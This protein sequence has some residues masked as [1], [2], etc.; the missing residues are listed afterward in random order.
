MKKDSVL[1][2]LNNLIKKKIIEGGCKASRKENDPT[3]KQTTL[4]VRP[5]TYKK[6][7]QTIIP[8][9]DYYNCRIKV[10]DLGKNIYIANFNVQDKKAPCTYS[11]DGE[12]TVGA[13]KMTEVGTKTKQKT[14]GWFLVNHLG[15]SQ[16]QNGSEC[17]N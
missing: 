1:K 7:E 15:A 4:R 13:G 9:D 17:D 14:T 10:R 6:S 8:I 3:A 16:I 5:N 11:D 2:E 12:F